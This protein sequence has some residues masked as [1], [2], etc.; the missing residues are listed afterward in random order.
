LGL[1]D[2]NTIVKNFVLHSKHTIALWQGYM[3]ELMFARRCPSQHI[4]PYVKK[5][6]L[7]SNWTVF[8]YKQGLHGT[9]CTCN[10]PVLCYAFCA[11]LHFIEKIGFQH[12]LHLQL[13]LLVRFINFLITVEIKKT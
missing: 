13:F 9:R 7:S 8:S 4:I 10:I 1:K 6:K 3:Q 12:A 11:I 2:L 5:T